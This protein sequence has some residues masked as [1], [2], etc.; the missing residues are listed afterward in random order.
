[1]ARGESGLPAALEPVA[2]AVKELEAELLR[3]DARRLER[4][5]GRLEPVARALA[6]RVGELRA[7]ASKEAVAGEVEALGRRMRRTAE[8]AGQ[9]AAFYRGLLERLA[10]AVGTYAAD[11]RLRTASKDSVSVRG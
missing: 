4:A 9:A 8:L 7:A 1:M 6:I 5:L 10:A 2:A 3:P 11:G